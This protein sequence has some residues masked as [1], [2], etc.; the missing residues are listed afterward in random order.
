VGIITGVVALLVLTML[1]DVL[2][3][4]AALGPI[5]H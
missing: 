1:V 2:A 3:V 5:T 4:Y